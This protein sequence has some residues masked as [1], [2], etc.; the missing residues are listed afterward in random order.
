M[1]SSELRQRSLEPLGC[2]HVPG[3]PLPPVA[4]SLSGT[5]NAVASLDTAM[6]LAV[7]A[8]SARHNS[9]PMERST[10]KL[11]LSVSWPLRPVDPLDSRVVARPH[12]VGAPLVALDLRVL[13]AT[14]S[15]ATSSAR[16]I[17]T[18]LTP[19]KQLTSLGH[20]A[21]LLGAAVAERGAV[22]SVTDDCYGCT[23]R[24]YTPATSLAQVAA[25]LVVAT[26]SRRLRTHPT[27]LAHVPL[28]ASL[29]KARLRSDATPFGATYFPQESWLVS[30]S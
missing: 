25:R 28:L 5:Q 10:Y 23:Q 7:R 18:R 2:P 20:T 17:D 21:A 14:R 9:G 13:V 11:A 27:A 26:Y 3:A 29:A 4:A 30:G 8:P 12:I 15:E 24:P 6:E 22:L 1:H 16:L 19:P